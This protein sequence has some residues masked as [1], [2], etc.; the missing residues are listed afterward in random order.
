MT[1]RRTAL[2]ALLAAS[3]L[4]PILFCAEQAANASAASAAGKASAL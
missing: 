3:A 2:F 1:Y 4:T